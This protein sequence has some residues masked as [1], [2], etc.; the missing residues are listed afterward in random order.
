M[1]PAT[2]DERTNGSSLLE[3]MVRR[4]SEELARLQ[5]EGARKAAG[6]TAQPAQPAPS[7]AGEEGAPLPPWLRDAATLSPLLLAYDR[8]LGSK[9]AI[10]ERQR[11]QLLDV[12]EEMRRVVGENTSLHEE[13]IRTK[14]CLEN[15]MEEGGATLCMYLS[16]SL[17]SSI[18]LP[19]ALCALVCIPHITFPVPL[20]AFDCDTSAPCI[21]SWHSSNRTSAR[22]HWVGPSPE[23]L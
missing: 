4:L 9:D 6:Q 15:A 21:A 17:V 14:S 19:S 8:Q 12:K 1:A 5:S 23:Q 16:C 10:I 13:V 11:L 2:G 20:T 7:I 3:E 22:R 18:P